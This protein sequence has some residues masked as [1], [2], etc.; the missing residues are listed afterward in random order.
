MRIATKLNLGVLMVFMATVI[1][2]YAALEMTVRPKFEEIEEGAARAN[3]K[4]VLDVVDSLA[5][6][7]R[8]SSQDNA[9]W[10]EAYAYARGEAGDSLI[11]ST[12]GS[13]AEALDALGIEL[14]AFKNVKDALLWGKAFELGAKR[15]LPTLVD[16]FSSLKYSHPFLSG[17]GELRASSGLFST[18]HGLMMLAVAPIVK[19]DHTGPPAGT[20]WMAT[21]LNVKDVEQLTGIGVRINLVSAEAQIE[22]LRLHKTADVVETTS[23]IRDITG[24][25]LALVTAKS[26]R[27]LSLVGSVAIQSAAWLMMFTAAMVILAMRA[28]VKKLVVSPV[29][30]L[31]A[32]FASTDDSGKLSPVSHTLSSD[33]IGDLARAFN[34]M[35]SRV[36]SLRDALL[37]SAHHANHAYAAGMAEWAAGTLHNV[38]NGLSPINI[39][40][41]KIKQLFSDD[42]LARLKAAI[43]QIES[44]D[45]PNERKEKL[46]SFVVANASVL[47]DH[48]ARTAAMMDEMV[49]ASKGIQAIASEYEI[50]SR[51]ETKLQEIDVAALVAEVAK[52]SFVT[53][54]AHIAV[55]LPKSSALVVGNVTIL[56]QVLSNLFLNSVEAMSSK[57]IDRRVRIDIRH[58][59]NGVELSVTD[60][61][62]GVAPEH[63]ASMFQRGFST[64]THKRGGLGLHWC[65][66]AVKS[67]GGTLRAESEGRGKG[68]TLI[69]FLPTPEFANSEAA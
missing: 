63:L 57:S 58:V 67:F 39:H 12:Y 51:Q 17:V 16:E 22:G 65:S 30:T 40:A 32:H 6:K 47:I 60:N 31:K 69:V 61:G 13:P 27:N 49:A 18:S 24:R 14:L 46:K 55:E 10:D 33:E 56:R 53:H 9:Y 8:A 36:S 64:R 11:T 4:R 54:E 3:H 29:Q 25:P 68:A 37:M 48:G 5:E 52:V 41:W 21:R 35:A 66:R 50:F 42:R 45:T 7:L 20:V 43:E 34:A 59:V 28:F 38:R 62:D 1:G 44:P 23:L 2:N 26:P 19:N 15:E